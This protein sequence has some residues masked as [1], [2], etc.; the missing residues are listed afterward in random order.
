MEGIEKID[1]RNNIETKE[2]IVFEL[3]QNPDLAN[4]AYETL[5]FK[6]KNFIYTSELIDEIIQ[7][8]DFEELLPVAK[9]F[10]KRDM[11]NHTKVFLSAKKRTSNLFTKNTESLGQTMSFIEN[12]KIASNISIFDKKYY[13][14]TNKPEHLSQQE[15]LLHEEIHRYTACI[16]NEYR[17]IEKFPGIEYYKEF[18][19]Y[20]NSF[21][22]DVSKE[23]EFLK[24][25]FNLFKIYQFQ[26][27]WLNP[28]EFITYGLTCDGGVKFLK[29][30]G[31]HG[32]EL[33]ER[34]KNS[35]NSKKDITLYDALL[36][37]F[38]YYYTNL[39][40]ETY[41]SNTD[42]FKL[43]FDSVLVSLEQ[44]QQAEHIYLEYLKTL[45]SQNFITKDGF[46]NFIKKEIIKTHN[47]SL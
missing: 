30:I 27:G 24:E 41:N 10:K 6:G 7:K 45:P 28:R 39:S 31:L 37:S 20:F 46:I 15:T 29:E 22:I 19:E 8:P 17:K 35:L 44:K 14:A 3:E 2:K 1:Q 32:S 33:T 23:I 42:T 25:Y 40:D 12:N 47:P 26:R 5:G 13:E 9:I 34:I 43:K 16:I 4:A 18:K 38:E 21:G 36:N 11:I